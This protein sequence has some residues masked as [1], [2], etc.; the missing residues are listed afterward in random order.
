MAKTCK[1][2]YDKIYDFANLYQ[3][4][5]RARRGKR[6]R[7]DV[8]CYS[9]NLEGNLLDLQRRL[10]ERAWMPGGFREKCIYEPKPRDIRIAPF[11]DRIVHHALCD[12]IGPLFEKTFIY[13][14]YACRVNKGTHAAAGRL[15]QFLRCSESA[16]CL[17]ADLSKYF[18]SVNHG[19]VIRELEWRIADVD[20]L[21]LCKRILSSYESELELIGTRDPKGIPIGNLTSQWFANIV[22]NCLDYHAKYILKA[23]HYLRYMDNFLILHDDKGFLIEAK[24]EMI[25]LLESLYLVLNPKTSIFPTQLGVPFLG[26]RVYSDHILPRGDNVRRG[27]KRIA[28]QLQ[29]VAHGYM[30]EAEFARSLRS[31]FAYLQQADTYSLRMQI[32]DQINEELDQC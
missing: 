18:D 1:H 23:K 15:Q 9:Q 3:A 25:R 21:E 28:R 5:M 22:G 17:S 32:A 19:V 16:Y 2:L 14:S 20:V 6:Y 30:S 12:V 31:W 13:D 24:L 26:Y 11:E 8:L 4:Y 7:D 29:K 27:R 10:C